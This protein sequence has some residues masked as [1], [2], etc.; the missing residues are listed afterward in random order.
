MADGSGGG[1]L[2]ARKYVPRGHPVSWLMLVVTTGAIL[3]NSIDRAILPAV[4]PGILSEFNLSESAGGFLIGLS[5][6]G[7]A[8]GGLVLGIFGDSLG[9][10]V[11]RAWG[12]AVAVA[13]VVVSSL[14]TAFSQTLG[15]L[16]VLRVAMGIGT[17]GMEPVNVAMVGEWW[18]KENRGFAVGT[19]HTGFPIGQFVGTLLIGAVLAAYSWRETFLFIPLI[20]LPIVVLQIFLARRENLRR[21][22]A[23]ILENGMTPS[24]TEEELDEEQR[25]RPL[26]AAWRA[27]R[28]ALAERNVRLSVIANFLFLWAEAGVVAFLT[29]QLTREA[30]LSLAAAVTISGASGITGWIGQIFWGT[31]SDYRGRKFS[32]SI[33]AVGWA[34]TVL[35]MIFISSGTLGWIILIG[36]GIF[37]NSPFPVMYASIIDAVPEGASSGLG[38]MIGIGLGLSGLVAAPVAGLLIQNFGFTVHY[39][40][41]AAICLLAL[42]PISMIGETATLAQE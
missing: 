40:F 25:E 6:A 5:F 12:W 8:V 19:H 2:A 10:G 26:P 42:V 39:V 21:V 17:G 23:W 37:R 35:S 18:Q 7:T 29:V 28:L 22:N 34:V 33:L 32:L 38:L 31:V 4:L 16:Q 15:Q 20:A 13:I 1:G 30:G 36:W 14:L 41:I 27:V 9:K 24:L 3:I 11:R